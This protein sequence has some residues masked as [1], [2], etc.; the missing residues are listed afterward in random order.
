[1]KKIFSILI[2]AIFSTQSF[3]QTIFIDKGEIEY[4]V[5]TQIKKTMGNSEWTAGFIDKLPDFKIS[6]YTLLFNGNESLYKFKNW[7]TNNSIPPFLRNDDEAAAWYINFETHKIL[8]TK[9]AFGTPFSIDDSIPQIQWK[10]TDEMRDIAGFNCRKAV[11]ILFDSVYVFAFFTNEITFSG[12]PASVQGLPGM[13]LGV[14]IPRLYTSW[15]ATKINASPSF[16]ALKP[17]SGKNTMTNQK[18]MQTITDRTK[19]WG[20][21]DPEMKRQFDVMKWTLML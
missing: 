11:G 19:G 17:I 18:L 16:A 15:M 21:N 3:A 4:E 12:G 9:N 20:G 13:V 8:K 2:I 10:L 7:P 5:K 14:T 6:Y 1:M